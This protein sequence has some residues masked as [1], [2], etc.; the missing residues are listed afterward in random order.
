MM[1]EFE[2]Y[3]A[4]EGTKVDVRGAERVYRR[5]GKRWR[6]VWRR[7]DVKDAPL[8]RGDTLLTEIPLESNETTSLSE[9][10]V[11]W[12][13]LGGKSRSESGSALTEELASFLG[14]YG[15]RLPRASR[16]VSG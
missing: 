11:H 4:Y 2:R 15:I 3:V 7:G 8:E 10:G 6:L 9:L 12:L 13:D 1:H 14:R 5:A 16:L